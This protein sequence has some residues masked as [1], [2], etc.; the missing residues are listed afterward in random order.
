M[1]RLPSRSDPECSDRIREWSRNIDVNRIDDLG[2]TLL[3]SS[4]FAGRADCTRVLLDAGANPNAA[5]CRGYTPLH[6][7]TFAGAPDDKSQIAILVEAGA[8]LEARLNWKYDSQLHRDWTPLMLAAAEGSATAARALLAAGANVNASD[9]LGMTPLMLAASQTAHTEE[10][11]RALI[12]AGGDKSQKALDG[13]IA[14]DFAYEHGLC[15]QSSHS[16]DH[17]LNS[18]N[19]LDE[20]VAEALRTA[21]ASSRE[22]NSELKRISYGMQQ[23]TTDWP[24]IVEILKTK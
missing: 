1:D 4:A 23:I 8:D 2:R 9:L 15:L 16:D 6:L 7:A 3:H 19:E 18:L 21:G 12:A 14:F 11:V 20:R 17:V 22:I 5:D 24:R 13:R 10:L